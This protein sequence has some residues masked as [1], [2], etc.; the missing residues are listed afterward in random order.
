MR[1]QPSYIKYNV[2]SK[3]LSKPDYSIKP[4]TNSINPSFYGSRKSNGFKAFALSLFALLSGT[5]IYAKTSEAITKFSNKA[6]V[7]KVIDYKG[8]NPKLLSQHLQLF[9]EDFMPELKKLSEDIPFKKS[10]YFEDGETANQVL[11]KKFK[12][13]KQLTDN[14]PNNV[15]QKGSEAVLGYR[16]SIMS[17]LK[18]CSE[19][20]AIYIKHIPDIENISIHAEGLQRLSSACEKIQ[21]CSFKNAALFNGFSADELM[22]KVVIPNEEL[23]NGKIVGENKNNLIFITHQIGVDNKNAYKSTFNSKAFKQKQVKY[24]D[25]KYNFDT[26]FLDHYDNI[27]VIQPGGISADDALNNAFGKIEKGLYP[28]AKAD[29]IYTAQGVTKNGVPKGCWLSQRADR[30]YFDETDEMNLSDFNPI[31]QGGQ[32]YA[33]SIKNLFKKAIDK[34][35]APRFIGE[36]CYS[37]FLNEAM[38]KILD[39]NY[40]TKV[41]VAGV[42]EEIK[43]VPIFGFIDNKLVYVAES[44]DPAGNARAIITIKDKDINW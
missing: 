19:Y 20:G 39:T 17:I 4:N 30:N 8:E 38:S 1:L 12:D 29:I 27:F 32:K 44:Y 6:P 35:Y 13:Y 36:G 40:L 14:I 3:S 42:P 15:L 2:Q 28:G 5:A 9:L 31:G 18:T 21:G 37:A 25:T 34:G 26:S 41:H 43:G 11:D 33:Q 7:L 22:Q 24:S 23:A 10:Y 16:Q